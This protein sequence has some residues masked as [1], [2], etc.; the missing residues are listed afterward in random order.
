MDRRFKRELQLKDDWN[1]VIST[2]LF[3]DITGRH[4]VIVYRRF[5]TTYRSH[6]H[7]SRVGLLSNITA[8]NNVWS[9]TADVI[10]HTRMAL[11]MTAAD[12]SRGLY[13]TAIY[14]TAI[15]A[16]RSKRWVWFK[17]RFYFTC[18]GKCTRVY[19]FI[20]SFILQSVLRQVHSLF[21]SE[22]FTEYDLVLPLS[23][24]SIFSYP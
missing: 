4:L 23:I 2:A 11:P 24:S 9:D 21:Q 8:G 5:G 10:S 19:S 7:G 18:T 16:F 22:F 15:T 14:C 6:V 13:Y 17:N 20:H 12:S 1:S 3:W